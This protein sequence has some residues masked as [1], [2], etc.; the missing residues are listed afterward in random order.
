MP[1][2][3]ELAL[4]EILGQSPPPPGEDDA[5]GA[6]AIAELLSRFASAVPRPVPPFLFQYTPAPSPLHCNAHLGESR[7][8]WIGA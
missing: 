8:E 7:R 6:A 1:T 3:D 2:P 4:L 5:G